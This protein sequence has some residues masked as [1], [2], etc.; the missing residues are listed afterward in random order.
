MISI[1]SHFICLKTARTRISTT[2]DIVIVFIKYDIIIAK[3]II[4]NPESHGEIFLLG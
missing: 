1:N 3:E 2:Y 4:S